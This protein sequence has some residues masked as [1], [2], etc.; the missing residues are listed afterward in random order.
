MRSKKINKISRRNQE[1]YFE[2]SISDE[3]GDQFDY[4]DDEF[5][6]QRRQEFEKTINQ[7]APHTETVFWFHFIYF[8]ISIIL[9]ISFIHLFQTFKT[10]YS[11]AKQHQIEKRL[12]KMM[13]SDA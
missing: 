12:M 8:M 4:A 6:R 11:T 5:Y 10:V 13:K 9:L 3:T 2:M 1:I 7:M